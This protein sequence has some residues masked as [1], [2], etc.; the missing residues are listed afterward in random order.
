MLERQ[1]CDDPVDDRCLMLWCEYL[2]RTEE[3]DRKL[4]GCWSNHDPDV[5]LVKDHWREAVAHARPLHVRT[6][7]AVKRVLTSAERVFDVIHEAK[8][9]E[10][11]L[12]MTHANRVEMLAGRRLIDEIL[13]PEPAASSRA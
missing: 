12:R 3:H 1:W 2:V 5:W 8:R 4:P 10:I 6:V 9:V 7:E 13:G 11:L